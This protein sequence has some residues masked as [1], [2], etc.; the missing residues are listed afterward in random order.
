MLET[1]RIRVLAERED[2]AFVELPCPG[3]GARTLG[4]VTSRS[5]G[6]RRL[7]LAPTCELGPADVARRAEAP[8]VDA[9]DVLDMHRFLAAYRGDLHALLDRPGGDG[10]D[11]TPGP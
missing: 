6:G 7:D 5:G 11:R 2:L 3:C 1:E 10:A 4:L 9:D 8:P